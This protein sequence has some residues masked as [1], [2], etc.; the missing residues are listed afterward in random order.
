[1]TEYSDMPAIRLDGATAGSNGFQLGPLSVEI[2]RGWVTAI[3][4]TNGSGKSTL[5]RTLLGL[6]PLVAG[7]ANVL[8]TAIRP[9]GDVSYKTRIGFISENAHSYEN[10]MTAADKARFAACWYPT[11]DHGRCRRLLE[12]FGVEERTKLSKMSKGMRRKA[13]L[14]IAM[15]HDP[16]L[17]LLDEPSSGLD[18]LIWK[19]WMEETQAFMASG[20]K[21]LLIA[22]HVTEEVQR[23][24]DHVMFM[25]RGRMIGFYEKD[26]LFDE[27]RSLLVRE[28]GPDAEIRKLKELPGCRRVKPEGLGVYRIDIDLGA[29][30]DEQQ[31]VMQACGFQVL[32]SRRLELEDILSCL[33]QKEDDNDEPA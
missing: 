2:P 12:R 27:W 6:E 1:M 21:T 10:S 3:V 29:L 20:D 16:E 7:S 13:E 18:P 19:V 4:G 22:T 5:F 25:H 33:I 28:I 23:L 26:R 24:A 11:W 14:A 31:S 8:G 9:D 17:L 15:A 30:P 32:E